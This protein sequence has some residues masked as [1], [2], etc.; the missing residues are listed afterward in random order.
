MCRCLISDPGEIHSGKLISRFLDIDDSLFFSFLA[1][2]ENKFHEI[3]R[4]VLVRGD[5]CALF[6]DFLEVIG[7]GDI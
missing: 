7:F 5:F 6:D 2:G 3:R 4:E 1:F